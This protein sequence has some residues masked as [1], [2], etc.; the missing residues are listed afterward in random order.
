MS[1]EPPCVDKQDAQWVIPSTVPSRVHAEQLECGQFYFL[2]ADVDET[3]GIPFEKI[4]RGGA[5]FLPDFIAYTSRSATLKKQKTRIIVPLA[6]PVDGRKYVVLQKILNDNLQVVGIEPDRATERAGQ[7]C[8]LP[9]RGKYYQHFENRNGGPLHPN[10]WA[11]D[12][13]AEKDR[14]KAI[15]NAAQRKRE[16]KRGARLKG[17]WRAAVRVR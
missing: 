2:W 17:A 10:D 16:K 1:V 13:Q 5:V 15:E 7:I 12:I 14:L 8:Y 11:K 6:E 4:V 9:N 3:K